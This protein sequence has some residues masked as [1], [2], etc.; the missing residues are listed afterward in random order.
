M[1]KHFW[2]LVPFV[3][4][5]V[6]GQDDSWEQAVQTATKKATASMVTIETSGGTETISSAAVPGKRRPGP[7]GA[8]GVR[9]G[10]GPTTGVV[11]STDGYIISS[12]FNFAN[13]PTSII[14]STAGGKRHVAKIIATDQSRMVTLLKIDAT[15]LP[16]P[17]VLP[18][19]SIQVGQTAIAMGKT[20][21]LT[22]DAPPSISVGII[23]AVGRIWGR[24]IQTDA[25][26]SPVNYGGPLVDLSG[27]VMGIL[28]PASPQAEGETAGFEWYDS[29][30]GFAMPLEQIMGNLERLKQGKDLRRGVMGITMQSND[31]YGVEP[32]VG[33][34]MPNSPAQKAG[35]KP[36]DK[37]ISV[38]GKNVESHAQMMNQ[39]GT[40]YEGDEVEVRI[41]RGT[42]E[43]NLGKVALA[44]SLASPPN[45]TLGILPM[46]D[47][48]EKGVEVRYVF[49]ETSAA[50]IGLKEGDRILKAGLSP[51]QSKTDA[52]LR[53][54]GNRE[55][56]ASMIHASTVGQQFG[57]E[58]KRKDGKTETLK[59]TLGESS[60]II[61]PKPPEKASLAKVSGADV[62]KPDLGLVSKN[63]AAGDKTFLLNVPISYEPNAGYGLVIWLHPTGKGKDKEMEDLFAIWDEYCA[64][65][66]FIMVAPRC[67]AELG[68]T[69]GDSDAIMEAI[70]F[71]QDN[72]NIDKKRIVLH[73]MGS[74]AQMSFYM[75]FQQRQLIRGVAAVGGAMGASPKERIATEPLAFF[76][77]VGDKDPIRESTIET[78]K[79]LL[80]FQYP[81]VFREMKDR[82]HQ[83]LD[84]PTL[85][86]IAT[87]VDLL[88]RL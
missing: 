7:A 44:G 27:K 5:M 6:Y 79:K 29:G 39:L 58:V 80:E 83:Y 57:M 2:I 45:G 67:D 25:K 46:R 4:L 81:C 14:I 62:K 22:P 59:G 85:D 88:D 1:I 18:V 37:I 70:K 49:P 3:G 47:D 16:M 43:L 30:I 75:A 54:I 72:Y 20:L 9:K 50:K 63:S 78:Q 71:A 38:A 41:K 76:L 87:W 74:G 11:V 64:R 8:P 32:I 55:E 73:G 34:V 10:S 53:P 33:G 66:K 28:V 61:P 26:V 77:A 86:Q 24:A 17:E 23:S 40:R 12:A 48:K 68:W 60:E 19:S 35:L 56:L 13:K 69:P 21:S 51:L 52:P 65:Y 42:E 82:G 84:S 31:M 15:G 36:G